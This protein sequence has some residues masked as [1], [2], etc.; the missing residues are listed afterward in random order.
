MP[1]LVSF[2]RE[3]KRK[4]ERKI[5]RER[6]KKNERKKERKVSQI[7]GNYSHLNILFS[8]SFCIGFTGIL[9]NNGEKVYFQAK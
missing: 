2:K 8:H 5:E 1:I 3:R 9:Y 6:T 7:Y 4:K